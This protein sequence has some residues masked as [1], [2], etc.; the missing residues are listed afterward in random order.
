MGG[1]FF[2]LFFITVI[3][4]GFVDGWVLGGLEE[5]RER[6]GGGR[7]GRINGKDKTC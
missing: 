1:F 5:K 7:S 3:W 4:A 6:G 2:F